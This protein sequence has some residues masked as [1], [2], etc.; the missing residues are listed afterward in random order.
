[1]ISLNVSSVVLKQTFDVR[2]VFKN[3]SHFTVFD[4]ILQSTLRDSAG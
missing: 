2:I 3:V 4:F 1:M